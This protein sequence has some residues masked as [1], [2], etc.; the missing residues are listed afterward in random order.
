MGWKY[1]FGYNI[2]NTVGLIKPNIKLIH[3][4]KQYTN[5]GRNSSS[6]LA[7]QLTVKLSVF[8]VYV[9]LSTKIFR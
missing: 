2:K 5:I 7:S 1:V 9:L 3:G 6:G 8:N 4:L